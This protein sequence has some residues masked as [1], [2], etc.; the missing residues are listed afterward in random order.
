MGRMGI[1]EIMEIKEIKFLHV[2]AV[3]T[4][5]TGVFFGLPVLAEENPVDMSEKDAKAVSRGVWGGDMQS[6]AGNFQG[7]CVPCHGFEGKGDG[8]LA[9]SFEVKPRNLT[10]KSIIG[11]RTDEFLFN[12][13]KKGG[14]SAGLSENMPDWG[15]SFSD[16]EIQNLVTYIRKDL[17]KCEFKGGN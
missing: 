12:L 17:C 1:K 3:V 14:K 13:I 5:L 16:T 9:E 11:K 7:N 2:C 6:G 15:T 4:V 10:D 8:P